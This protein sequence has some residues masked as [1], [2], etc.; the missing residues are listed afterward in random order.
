MYFG[1]SLESSHSFKDGTQECGDRSN[2]SSEPKL[3]DAADYADDRVGRDAD[4]HCG[5]D[6]ENARYEK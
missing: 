1:A 5:S 4:L 2:D 3:H 6:V